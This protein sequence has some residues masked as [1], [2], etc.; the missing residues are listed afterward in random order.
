MQFTIVIV[1]LCAVCNS[2]GTVITSHE[3][4]KGGPNG[5]SYCNPG[6]FAIK[7][8]LKAEGNQGVGDDTAANAFRLVCSDGNELRSE[9]EGQ[10]GI[11]VTDSA[12]P[13]DYFITGFNVRAE[14]DGGAD[15]TGMNGIVIRCSRCSAWNDKDSDDQGEMGLTTWGTFAPTTSECDK[16]MVVNGFQSVFEGPQGSAP[17]DDDSSLN[18]VRM[19]CV[20]PCGRDCGGPNG[21]CIL[22]AKICSCNPQL[23]SGQFCTENPIP[24]PPAA[25]QAA[26]EASLVPAPLIIDNI[27]PNTATAF[28]GWA[29]GVIIAGVVILLI[30]VLVVVLAVLGVLPLKKSG[31]L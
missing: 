21:S 30:L 20:H 3:G 13:K 1:L 25:P 4:P 12:C 18:G 19:N 17:W 6:T 2:F 5:W 11:W 16:D 26:P 8:R 9:P 7:A 22:H 10:W 29:I 24:L 27:N 15:D 28:P 14:D 31:E 23:A